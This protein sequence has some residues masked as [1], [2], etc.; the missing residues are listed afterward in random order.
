MTRGDLIHMTG[1][2]M[3]I[4]TR[5]KEALILRKKV[6]KILKGGLASEKEGN[7]IFINESN[8]VLGNFLTFY[9][10]TKALSRCLILLVETGSRT[11]QNISV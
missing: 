10:G 8:G 7:F 2:Q 6:I 5:K 11:A 4:I 1:D 9:K 3:K